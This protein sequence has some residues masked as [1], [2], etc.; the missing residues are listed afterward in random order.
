MLYNKHRIRRKYAR[1]L[2]YVNFVCNAVD[3][4][5]R[6]PLDLFTSKKKGGAEYRKLSK[7]LR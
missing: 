3:Q 4:K 7:S 6:M 2:N 5:W 1:I